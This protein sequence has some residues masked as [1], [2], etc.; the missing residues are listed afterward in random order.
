M[1][2]AWHQTLLVLAG[3]L[4]AFI[5]LIIAVCFCLYSIFCGR[6]TSSNINHS[7]VVSEKPSAPAFELEE[8][9]I[10]TTSRPFGAYAFAPSSSQ[11][12]VQHNNL[13][14][15]TPVID[16]AEFTTAIVDV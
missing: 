6:R 8:G 1:D 15:I 5:V 10:S 11:L 3:F 9:V 12:S 14:P 4:T 13:R 2:L 7:E 16:G